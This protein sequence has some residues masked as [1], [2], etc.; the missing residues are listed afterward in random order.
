MDSTTLA[1]SVQTT[2][3]VILA[4]S[5]PVLG[6]TILVGFV[7]GLFQAVT[8]IQDQSLPQAVKIVAVLVGIA[9]G[10]RTISNTLLEHTNHV[11]DNLPSIGSSV[12]R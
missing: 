4:L 11:M 9:I 2:L 12:V 6:I 8:Q 5:A 7:L 3:L 1:S 10:G